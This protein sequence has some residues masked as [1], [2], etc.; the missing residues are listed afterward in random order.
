[1]SKQQ[2]EE[3]VRHYLSLIGGK[4]GRVKSPA[5]AESSRANGLKGGRPSEKKGGTK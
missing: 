4:G 5:K 3:N 1:M 2:L